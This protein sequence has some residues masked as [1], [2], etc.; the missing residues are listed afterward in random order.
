MARAEREHPRAWP[1]P[2]EVPTRRSLETAPS[3][4][5][6]ELATE[7]LA[8]AQMLIEELGRRPGDN[9]RGGEP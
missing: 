6:V 1:T 7:F 4:E 8:D 2:Q 5:L 3:A 9:Q